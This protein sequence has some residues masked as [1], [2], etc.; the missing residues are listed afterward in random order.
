MDIFVDNFEV[1]IDWGNG[2]EE[3]VGIAEINQSL[4]YELVEEDNLDVCENTQLMRKLK[5]E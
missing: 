1:Y 4:A 3:L 5:N 2:N